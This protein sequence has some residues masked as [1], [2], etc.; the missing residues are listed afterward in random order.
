MTT[1]D[2]G[3]EP[4]LAGDLDTLRL[5]VESLYRTVTRLS[6]EDIRGR[7]RL[8]GWSR[9]HLLT[10]LA[11]AADSRTGLLVA[12]RG[13]RVGRQYGSERIR[14]A[15]I[16]SGARRPPQ[17]IRRDLTR[18]FQRFFSAVAEH[19]PSRWDDPGDWL[20]LGLRPVRRTV[21]SLRREVEYHHV[22]LAAGYQPGDWPADF[23]RDELRSVTASLRHRSGGPKAT[24]LPQGDLLV[25]DGLVIRGRPAGLLAWLTGRSDGGD[26]RADPPGRLPALP[27][28]G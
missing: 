2:T 9:A 21:P 24:L 20:D 27:P 26:L 10:H 8:P 25:G 22:D 7:S 16:E 23:V 5:A 12:A 13:G 28:L 11:R 4:A 15:E 3:A 1:T 6:D 14:R 17:D 19:P 18:A